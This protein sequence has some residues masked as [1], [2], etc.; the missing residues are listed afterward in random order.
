MEA[1]TGLGKGIKQAAK[2]QGEGG[3]QTH[4]ER[5]QDKTRSLNQQGEGKWGRLQAAGA[6]CPWGMGEGEDMKRDQ[7]EKGLDYS[8]IRTISSGETP[9]CQKENFSSCL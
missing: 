3:R 8:G 6:R 7:G 4:R 2:R 1:W 9:L 5:K